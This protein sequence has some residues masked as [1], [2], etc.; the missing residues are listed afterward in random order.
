MLECENNSEET[1]PDIAAI[2]W[3]IIKEHYTS[4]QSQFQVRIRGV[5]LLASSAVIKV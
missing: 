1:E 5:K 2:Q 3:L 4:L